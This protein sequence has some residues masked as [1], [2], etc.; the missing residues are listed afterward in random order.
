M[1]WVEYGKGFGEM[2]DADLAKP[3]VVIEL[4][5]SGGEDTCQ[6]LIGDINE[7]GGIC[8][9]CRDVSRSEVVL[10]YAVVWEHH[11]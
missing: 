2:R 8:D 6:L 7:L 4:A 5:G 1:N 9:C 3:G 10:R 11:A